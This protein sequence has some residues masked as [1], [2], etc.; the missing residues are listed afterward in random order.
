MVAELARGDYLD[1]QA[2][3][4]SPSLDDF[5]RLNQLALRIQAGRETTV[6]NFPRVG[7]A[8][9]VP[10]Y[11]PTFAAISWY[12]TFAERVPCDAETK[13]TFWFFALAHAR[14]PNFFKNLT[15]A[16]EIAAAVQ[17]WADDLPVTREEVSRA[18]SYA[19]NGFDDAQPARPATATTENETEAALSRLTRKLMEIVGVGRVAL[20]DALQLTQDDGDALLSYAYK[21]MG[22]DYGVDDKRM[23]L[24][25][26][27]TLAEIRERLLKEKS[28]GK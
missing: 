13:N 26:N 16:D 6:A 18:C 8:G 5:D 10:F 25:Y 19:A 2:E 9:E 7:W 23:V 4:L 24:D 3:G 14:R 27:N 28:D 11:Q 1:L 17:R 21:A 20:D 22:R 12:L 15:T